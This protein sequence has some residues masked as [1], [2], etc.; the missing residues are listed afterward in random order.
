MLLGA[1]G[2]LSTIYPDAQEI[3][4]PGSR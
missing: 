4:D 3:G 1:I 2:A